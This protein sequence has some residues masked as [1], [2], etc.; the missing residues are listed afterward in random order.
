[1]NVTST[2]TPPPTV[3]HPLRLEPGAD[4]R[5]A[6]ETHARTALGGSAFVVA[7]IG[8]LDGARLRLAAADAET[9]LPGPFE[10]L[11]L[12]GSLS[13]HGAHL[14]MSVADA[15]GRVH[16]GHVPYGNR[17]RTTVE[18]LLAT[19]AAWSLSRVGDP[20]TGHPELVVHGAPDAAALLPTLQALEV[21]LHH[22]GVRCDRARLEHLLHPDFHEVG[23]SGQVYTRATIINFLSTQGGPVDVVSDAFAVAPAAPGAALL[24]YRSAHRAPDGTLLRHTLRSSL[25]L[26]WQG[27]WRLRYHQGTAAAQPW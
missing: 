11:S 2:P 25:W 17:V 27:A 21:E 12:S 7:G 9:A 1:M 4:V 15:E 26:H 20:A 23:R 18:V 13:A 16:G 6:L 24:T 14:H 5:R 19:S 10:I 3:T 22:P 8:S